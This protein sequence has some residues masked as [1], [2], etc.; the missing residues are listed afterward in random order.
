MY[1]QR[2]PILSACG[3][4]QTKDTRFFLV[5]AIAAVYEG[6]T[7]RSGWGVDDQDSRSSQS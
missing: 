4:L 1:R 2:T 6:R 7:S 3:D 5:H